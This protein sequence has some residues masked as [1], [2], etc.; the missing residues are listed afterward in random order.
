M[1][2]RLV[3][4]NATIHNVEDMRYMFESSK[5]AGDLS[6]WNT[7]KV[8]NMLKMFVHSKFDG[9]ISEWDTNGVEPGYGIDD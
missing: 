3:A 1:K 8:R 6:K 7:S 9:D 5:F 2:D 4:T